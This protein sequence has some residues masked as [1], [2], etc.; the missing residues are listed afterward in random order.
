MTIFMLSNYPK[1][2]R[3]CLLM[4]PENESMALDAFDPILKETVGAF[5]ESITFKISEENLSF[6]PKEVC[7]ACLNKVRRYAKFCHQVKMVHRL[8]DSMA[9]HKLLNTEPLRTLFESSPNLVEMLIEMGLCTKTDATV[10]DL[11]DEFPSYGFEEKPSNEEEPLEEEGSNQ[12]FMIE[13]SHMDGST[14][15]GSSNEESDEKF[16]PRTRKAAGR[17]RIETKSGKVSEPLQ[18]TQCKFKT[19]YKK[20]LAAHQERHVRKTHK[21]YE[22]LKDGCTETFTDVRLYRKHS[23]N[24]HKS[25]VCEECGLLV[26]T[27][28]GLKTH[29]ERHQK[30]YGYQCPYC[31]ARFNAKHDLSTHKRRVHL[32]GTHECDQ[33]GQKFNRKDRLNDHIARHMGVL[34]HECPVCGKKFV[35]AAKLKK[36][37]DNVHDKKSIPCEHCGRTFNHL[38]LLRDHIEYAHGIQQRFVCDIC[39]Q[40]FYSQEALDSHRLR[41]ENPKKLECSRCLEVFPSQEQLGDHLC[42]TY[43]NDYVC[44][45]RDHHNH[46]MYN[47]HMFSEHGLKTNVR[48]KPVPGQMLGQ[49]RAKRKRK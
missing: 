17:P 39:L 30:Q 43:R 34:K 35:T 16:K 27:K 25:F 11:L 31:D 26:P 21:L 2:C 7:Q 29:M 48:V 20:N 23:L 4:V 6:L 5:V 36:H 37:R 47:R 45:G 9:E 1:L 13:E 49:I 42:I 12:I 41:H 32:S 46:G 44:C 19:F 8:M 33:C 28:F 18:C 14:T 40:L 15:D 3:L 10:Q 24:A 38:T 22:C